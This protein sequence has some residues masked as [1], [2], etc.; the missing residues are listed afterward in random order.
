MRRYMYVIITTKTFTLFGQRAGGSAK[1][2]RDS[3][4]HSTFLLECACC[5]AACVVT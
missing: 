1:N 3:H 5:P 2:K 4:L